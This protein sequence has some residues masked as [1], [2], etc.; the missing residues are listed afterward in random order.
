MNMPVEM[1][2][3][4]DSLKSLLKSQKTA[5]Q[6]EPAPTAQHRITQLTALKK[7]FV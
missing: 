3:S 1:K 6:L 4:T 2:M 7:R 5:Y